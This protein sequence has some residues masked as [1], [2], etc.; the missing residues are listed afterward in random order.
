MSAQNPEPFTLDMQRA[1]RCG[2]P[3]VVF[4]EGGLFDVNRR[5]AG[6]NPLADLALRHHRFILIANLVGLLGTGRL[7]G[8]GAQDED[9][10]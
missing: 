8:H 3:E 2:Y 10:Q 7:G 6:L 9:A 5:N 1:Q 4:G